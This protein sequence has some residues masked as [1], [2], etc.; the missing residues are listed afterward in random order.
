MQ[1]EEAADRMMDHSMRQRAILNNNSIY[2]LLPSKS[3]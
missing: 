2:V 3:F 1:D